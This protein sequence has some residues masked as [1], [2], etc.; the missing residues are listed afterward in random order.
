MMH[1]CYQ[2]FMFLDTLADVQWNSVES[3]FRVLVMKFQ[4]DSS[5]GQQDVRILEEPIIIHCRANCDDKN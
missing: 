3:H 4:C 5:M 1:V 2:L